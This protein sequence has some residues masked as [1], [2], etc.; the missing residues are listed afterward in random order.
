M[1]KYFRLVI[2]RLAYSK[3]KFIESS[4]MPIQGRAFAGKVLLHLRAFFG[5]A[6][7]LALA[8]AKTAAQAGC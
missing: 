5:S 7:A 8:D 2:Y 4:E 3:N 1:E 6:M